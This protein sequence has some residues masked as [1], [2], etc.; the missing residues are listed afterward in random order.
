MVAYFVT[1]VLPAL[2]TIQKQTNEV[3]TE[4]SKVLHGLPTVTLRSYIKKTRKKR[5]PIT[6]EQYQTLP[7]RHAFHF[8]SSFLS[9]YFVLATL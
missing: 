3:F 5:I 8:F 2:E 9:A 1:S 6:L 7:F 4:E